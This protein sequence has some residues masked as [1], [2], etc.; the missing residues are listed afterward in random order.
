[1]VEARILSNDLLKE[2]M[3]DALVNRGPCTDFDTCNQTG[4]WY[5]TN[6][7]ANFPKGAYQYGIL[8]VLRDSN[9]TV[10]RYYPDYSDLVHPIIWT[11][12]INNNSSR[13]W[14]KQTMTFATV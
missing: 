7:T 10:Q 5:V 14:L 12:F 2:T 11:R 1:M 9:Y 4:I 6:T 8:V 13:G 3:A